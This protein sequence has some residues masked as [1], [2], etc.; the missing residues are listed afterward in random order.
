MANE[1]ILV[2]EDEPV[3][4]M[5]IKEDLERLGF[6]V[7]EI[8]GSG[9]EVLPAVARCSPDLVLMDIHLEGNV[10]GIEA[11]LQVKAEF[12]V[13]VLYLTA[14]SDSRTLERAAAT[15]PEAFL[16]K[17]F[18]ERDLAV[19][20]RMALA[21]AKLGLSAAE[22]LEQLLPLAD[23][24]ERAALV[25]D[26]GGRIV[27][28]N[29]KALALLG[30]EG[31]ER[32]RGEP[33][34][35]YVTEAGPGDAE[36][37]PSVQSAL[38]AALD[39]AVRAEPIVRSDGKEIGTLVSFDRMSAEE[40]LHL[41]SSVE[42]SNRTLESLLPAPDAA[43][44]GFEVGAFLMACPSGTGDLADVF[45]LDGRYTAFYELDVMGHG[46][47]SSLVAYSLHELLHGL[48]R[49]READAFISPSR[50][51]RLLNERYSVDAGNRPFFTIVYGVLDV[52]SG[53]Y[54]LARAGHPPVVIL[55]AGGG[56][57]SRLDSKGGAIGVLDD[58]E[59][60]EISGRLDL[61]DRLLVVSD[62]Y[63]EALGGKD[64]G[65]SMDAF[66]ASLS[67]YRDEPAAGLVEA[68]RGLARG[69]LARANIRDD[70]S[71]LLI[72][73]GPI[74]ARG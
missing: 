59:V 7:P 8:V 16:L 32:L 30:L 70:A 39:V 45:R 14:Y 64:Y 4:G 58:I 57:P 46:I 47:F 54:R 74:A 28:A 44:P 5:E 27:H 20:V 66:L 17:P 50:L 10:D 26:T 63:L 1:K 55:P 9:E 37:S 38:G 43:G 69:G 11:A 21:K 29:A 22:E 41:E 73:R 52:S 61:G 72:E 12:G 51:L 34:S 56:A 25:V 33:L 15:G 53:E 23:A 62:G 60:E 19:S 68:L 3:V 71:L 49:E 31:G 13:P 42:E 18:D 40:R 36:G 65:A 35:R 67:L 6:L 48:A 24:L 2:V